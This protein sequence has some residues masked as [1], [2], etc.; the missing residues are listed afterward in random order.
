MENARY[1]FKVSEVYTRSDPGAVMRRYESN[2]IN[3]DEV[4]L[5]NGQGWSRT[6]FFERQRLGHNDDDFIEVPREE[7]EE[8]IAAMHRRGSG[9]NAP[10]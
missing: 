8:A 3:Y 10:S 6:E 5:F 4:Y 1:Y 2:G 9:R 7:A